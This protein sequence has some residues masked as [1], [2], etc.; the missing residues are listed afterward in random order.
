M[1][2]ENLVLWVKNYIMNEVKPLLWGDVVISGNQPIAD[3]SILEKYKNTFEMAK[4]ISIYSTIYDENQKPSLVELVYATP[5]YPFY[6]TFS[7][8]TISDSGSLIIDAKTYEKYGSTLEILWKKYEVKGIITSQVLQEISLYGNSQKIYLPIENFSQELNASNSRINFEYYFQF[9][10]QYN[11]QI[12]A[13]L[14][15]VFRPLSMRVS[16]LED[17]NENIS[18]ITDRFYIFI[19]FFNSTLFILTF[20]IVILSL[21]TYFKKMKPTL[22][23]LSIFGLQK[24]RIFLYNVAVLLIVFVG[25]F[26]GASLLNLVLFSWISKS[27]EFLSFYPQILWSGAMVWAIITSVGTGLPLYKIGRSDIAWLLKNNSFFTQFSWKDYLLYIGVI[28]VWFVAIYTISHTNIVSSFWYSFLIV[29]LLIGLYIACEKLLVFLFEKSKKIVK[30]FYYFD[31]LRSSVRPGNV[32]FFIIFASILSF[33]SLLVFYVFSGSFLNYLQT[34]STKSRDVFA[35]NIQKDDLEFIKKYFTQDEIYEIVPL[36]IQKINNKTLEEYLW[37]QKVPRE[38]SREFFST[39]SSLNVPVLRGKSLSSGGVS[40]DKEMADNL[41]LSIGDVIIF[42]SAGLEKSLVV[43]NIRE[44]QRNG[45][46]PFFYFVLDPKDFEKYPKNYIVSYK[47]SEKIPNIQNIISAQFSGRITFINA[48]EIIALVS[49]ISKKIVWVVYVCLG[50]LSIFSVLSFMVSF[51]FLEWFL[52]YKTK[53]L[54]I[55]WG[56][57]SSLRNANNF[58]YIY[59]LAVG[60]ILSIIVGSLILWIIFSL[61]AYFN[62]FFGAYFIALAGVIGGTFFFSF[63]VVIKNRL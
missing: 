52:H 19:N 23:L 36:R 56:K 41:E 10:N 5:N 60:C 45:T 47:S 18:N 42:S 15:E 61:I 62:L 54:H 39:T 31:A 50:Y 59:L 57:K 35:I 6:G 63:Y 20:F 2:G 3:E 37:T 29:F 28:F 11:S 17:R 7:Y 34:I 58:W 25:A 12:I 30:N 43:Q 48:W 55:L 53:L 24:S 38:Y 14:K 40:V 49:E 9:K 13:E 44:A 26:I 1:F 51:V 33:V 16:S 8:E 46:D 4:T 32:S 22:G 21:E 27:Y